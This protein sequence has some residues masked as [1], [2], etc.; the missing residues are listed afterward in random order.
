MVPTVA[1]SLVFVTVSY[2]LRYILM[3]IL[4]YSQPCQLLYMDYVMTRCVLFSKKFSVPIWHHHYLT[5]YGFCILHEHF[6]GVI[7]SIPLHN[8]TPTHSKWWWIILISRYKKTTVRAKIIF[9][10][11]KFIISDCIVVIF[12][13]TYFMQ[14]IIIFFHEQSIIKNHVNVFYEPFHIF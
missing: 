1:V 3:Y 6:D 8:L 9:L 5:E 4:N 14:Q 7:K 13:Q 2:Y 11:T 10:I 12:I